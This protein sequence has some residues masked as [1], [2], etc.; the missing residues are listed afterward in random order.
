MYC[1]TLGQRS[2]VHIHATRLRWERVERGNYCCLHSDR[3][4]GK[5]WSMGLRVISKRVAASAIAFV[6][7]SSRRQDHLE[8]KQVL[9]KPLKASR[10]EK[11]MAGVLAIQS[12]STIGIPWSTAS[13]RE[14]GIEGY[15]P[16]WELP[17]ICC[18]HVFKKWSIWVQRNAMLRCPTIYYSFS[19]ASALLLFFPSALVLWWYFI[20]SSKMIP[21][22]PWWL[23]NLESRHVW[24]KIVES[25]S[26][27]SSLRSHKC[28]EAQT[29]L[30]LTENGCRFNALF[31]FSM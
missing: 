23:V 29:Q 17:G 8:S 25:L 15:R 21:I 24:A 18:T 11:V 31:Q 19:L 5:E 2:S 12:A 22:R 14:H 16:H 10:G 1:L 9:R 26:L 30:A 20:N 27:V 3:A 4:K 13:H 28:S 6:S 7:P